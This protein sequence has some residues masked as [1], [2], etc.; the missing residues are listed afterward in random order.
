MPVGCHPCFE[1]DCLV[2]AKQ[3]LPY[4][5]EKIQWDYCEIQ[6]LTAAARRIRH[7]IRSFF[8]YYL[9]RVG[10]VSL[11]SCC[12]KI[13]SNYIAAEFRGEESPGGNR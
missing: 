2:A 7:H 6:P 1:L 9:E 8:R 10:P 5:V 11:E 3:M 12:Y 13:R 4:K